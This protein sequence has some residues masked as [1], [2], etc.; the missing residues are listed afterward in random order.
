MPRVVGHIDLD[1]FYAQVE[2]VENPALRT[3]P[4][5]VCVFSGRTEESG[6]VATA[7]YL[8]RAHGARSGM[9][10]VLAKRKLQG[11][12]P[13]LIKMVRTKYEQVSERIMELLKGK[14]DILEQTGIDEA[15]FDVTRTASGSFP[16]A[17]RTATEVKKSLLTTESLT[18]SIGIGQSKTVA[19]IA[20]D[21]RKPDGLTV[22]LPEETE[23][24]LEPLTIS[25]LYGV[26]PKTAQLLEGVGVKTIGELAKAPFQTLERVLGRK[27]A[28]Y[29]SAASR[30]EDDEPVSPRRQQTQLSRI[31]T[32]KQNTS[33]AGIAFAQLSEALE[34]LARRLHSSGL[35]FKTVTAIAILT[36]LS[37]K[38]KSRTLDGPT[39][40]TATMTETARSLLEQ[41]AKASGKEFRR[42]GVRLSDL[43]S[44][45]DQ[46]SLG[47]F[48]HEE[49]V[50]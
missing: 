29:L 36:D 41:L 37:T 47:E 21:F 6:V 2:E 15:F 45:K 26:G 12:D 27:L 49:A 38:T 8:A 1:Y 19:K 30:G 5:L 33:D 3:R 23:A 24:F 42:V 28:Q 4:V 18:C 46:T 50:P 10:I 43:S 48:L 11:K 14:V 7:N 35:A 25:K 40:D 34:D 9:P 44:T 13:V 20:S 39:S 31:V 16:Q 17:E 32:L 22:I